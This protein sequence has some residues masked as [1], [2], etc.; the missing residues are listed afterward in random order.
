[1]S[2]ERIALVTGTSS[3]I[4]AAVARRLLEGG[5][6]V[7]GVARRTS[8]F[9]S[10][11]YR[12]LALDLA[13]VER[14][15]ALIGRE[16]GARLAERAWQRVGLVNNA[17]LAPAGRVQRIEASELARAYALNAV[18]PL[19]LMGFVLRRRPDGAQVRVVNISS[20]AAQ[21]PF[22]GLATYCSTKAAL[23]MAG[24][25]VAAEVE[26]VG[27]F[28][29]EPGVVDTEMQRATRER[30]LE[31]FPWGTT[32]RQYHA[33]GRLVAPEL[34][35]ADVVKFLES[36]RTERFVESRRS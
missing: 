24:M 34:P 14:A 6:Q 21:R 7:V 36:E 17:A 19:W 28:S 8:N 2:G 10:G 5:W 32:F 22:P 35:A 23:R 16:F 33:E 26:D 18:M 30:P 11:N 15:T 4:G 29:Y 20:G 1:M 27:V 13:E 9:E 3:G 31:E 25:V 12:H